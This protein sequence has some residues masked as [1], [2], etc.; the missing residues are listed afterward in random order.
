MIVSVKKKG[1][2]KVVEEFRGVTVS[3]YKICTSVL[4]ERLLNEM[5]SKKILSNGQTGFRKKLGTI[6]NIYTLNYT[7]YKYTSV[8]K[9]KLI[10]L[11]VDLKATF[12][13]VDRE[14]L[15]EVMEK[16]G[17]SER[18]KRKIKRIYRETRSRVKVGNEL[19]ECFWTARGIKQGCLLSP[20]LF[21]IYLSDLENELGKGW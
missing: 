11:F 4:A 15:W 2:G 13:S 10:A 14:K 17:I 7:I 20:Y 12:D 21:N 1:K 19:E 3:L 9:K 16:K 18:M 8:E 6:G 5:E